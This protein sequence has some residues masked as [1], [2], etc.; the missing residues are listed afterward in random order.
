MFL[1]SGYV[2]FYIHLMYLV[3]AFNLDSLTAAEYSLKMRW[4]TS[5]VNKS[6]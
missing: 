6:K 2:Q 4:G 5:Q 3:I 1:T